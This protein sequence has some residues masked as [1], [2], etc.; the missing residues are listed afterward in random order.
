ME[1][2]YEYVRVADD[3]A[4][5]IEGGKIPVGGR[6]SDE[7][8]LADEYGVSAG[9]VRRAVQELRDRGLVTTLPGKGTYVVRQTPDV[10]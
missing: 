8:S 9:T 4:R 2:Q 3:L 10:S 6:L 7:R 1:I 5:Q